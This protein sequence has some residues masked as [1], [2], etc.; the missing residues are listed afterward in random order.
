VRTTV[1][2]W[3]W[4]AFSILG[5][6]FLIKAENI[7]ITQ[8]YESNFLITQDSEKIAQLFPASLDRPLFLWQS[9]T[10]TLGLSDPKVL[11]FY[12]IATYTAEFYNKTY[13]KTSTGT[14]IKSQGKSLSI[15]SERPIKYAEQRWS[16]FKLLVEENPFV[17]EKTEIISQDR[18]RITFS[19]FPDPSTVILPDL[20]SISGSPPLEVNLLDNLHQ[21]DLNLSKPLVLDDSVEIILHSIRSLTGHEKRDFRIDLFYTDGIADIFAS[22]KNTII[23]YLNSSI[24]LELLRPS[25]FVITEGLFDFQITEQDL[26]DV[27]QLSV[28]P[29]LEEGQLYQ[30]YI[31]SRINPLGEILAGSVRSFYLDRTPPLPVH[32]D[33]IDANQLSVCFDEAVDPVMAIVPQHYTING[34]S[35]IEVLLGENRNQVILVMEEEVENNYELKIEKVEDLHGNTIPN[36]T[37]IA[38][39]LAATNSLGYK[40]IVI[41]EV[42][43][44]PRAGMELP[45]AEYVELFNISTDEIDISGFQLHNSRTGTTLPAN[46]ILSPGEYLLLCP[47]AR[48]GLLEPYGRVIGLPRWPVLLN[49]ADMVMLYDREGNLI[50]SLGYTRSNYGSNQIAQSGYSLEIVNPY[51]QCNLASNLRPSTSPSRGTPGAV[52]AVYDDT[53]DRTPPIL[54][55]VYAVNNTLLIAVF[56]KPLSDNLAA[57]KWDFSPSIGITQITFSDEGQTEIAIS[58]SDPLDEKVRYSL[59]VS[60]IRDCSGNL[61]AKEGS[62]FYFALPLPAEVGDIVINEILFNPHVGTPKFVEIY[63]TSDK[64]INLRNWKLGNEAGG[65]ISNRRVISGFDMVIAPNAYRAFTTDAGSLSQIYPKATHLIELGSLPSYPIR[66]GTVFLLNPSEDIVER[67]DYHERYHHP[68]LRSPRGVSLERIDPLRQ[69]N[70]PNNWASAA[71]SI[72]FA[73]PGKRNSQRFSEDNLAHGITVSPEVFAPETA[74]AQNFTTIQYQL[75]RSGY[76]GTIKIY[77]ISGKIIKE[78]VQNEVWGTNGFYTWNGTDTSGNRVRTGYYI[79]WVE[80]LNLEGNV[81]NFK[82][83]VAVGAKIR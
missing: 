42:M 11:G 53:P 71:G 14:G 12:Q 63:N 25:D 13:T 10:D 18:I 22:D 50:D 48:R 8:N 82:K 70:D 49:N 24:D 19:D 83:T 75:E 68:L 7:A 55:D 79:I 5:L 15:G 32:M 30:L 41:N 46:T 31:P 29:D 23:L 16:N 27:L 3:V 4:F 81:R 45:N 59:Q 28:T 80:L 76:V 37:R 40:S 39:T 56:S 78:I 51:S 54:Q 74:G 47:N 64:Y 21:I 36:N 1:Y 20:Y 6:T 52:N 67:L 17:I 43:A 73:T 34:I 57:V 69:P 26:P 58:L 44:A 62:T 66:E 60:N 61:L 9:N 72:G 35:P 38:S 77:D 65:I 2:V 33:M